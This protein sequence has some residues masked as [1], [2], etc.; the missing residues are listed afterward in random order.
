M[1]SFKSF[2]NLSKSTA[3]KRETF[4]KKL[5]SYPFTK[6]E[7]DKAVEVPGDSKEPKSNSY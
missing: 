6:D 2:S 4:W 3:K 7:Y 5:G 1:P